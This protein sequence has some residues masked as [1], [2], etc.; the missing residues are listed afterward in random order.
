MVL[1]GILFQ[2]RTREIEGTWIDLFEGSSF[3]ENQ[4]IASACSPDFNSA[5]YFAYYPK[6]GTTEY[7]LV[8]ANRQRLDEGSALF[9]SEHGVW[10]VTAYS[11]KFVGR[12]QVLGIGFGH[13]GSHPSQYVVERVIS[14][15]PIQFTECDI[16]A[17]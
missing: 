1:F 4:D 10:P 9:V 16:R 13:F 15:E 2:Q 12:H 17:S 14:I 8:E 11:V 6:R 7:R 5:P 3:F